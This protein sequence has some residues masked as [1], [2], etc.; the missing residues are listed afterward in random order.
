MALRRR[1]RE[2]WE[3][4]KAPKPGQ[5]FRDF[6]RYRHERRGGRRWSA[7]RILTLG[8]GVLLVGGGLAIGWLPGP[9]GFIAVFGLALLATEWFALA[10]LLDWAELVTRRSWAGFTVYWAHS[11]T[12]RR[13]ATAVGFVGLAAGASYLVVE[14][15]MG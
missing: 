4:L 15:L 11:S 10:K 1:A 3:R 5:R 13:V 2:S 9:G 6:Y 7:G 12:T 8:A 14:V